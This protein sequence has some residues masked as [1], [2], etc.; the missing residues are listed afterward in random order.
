M[1]K[2]RGEQPHLRQ[3]SAR[4]HELTFS[5]A[6]GKRKTKTIHARN[7]THARK[8]ASSFLDKLER[9]RLGLDNAIELISLADAFKEYSVVACTKSSWP[10]EFG[11]WKNHILELEPIE[12]NDDGI[13]DYQRA[14]SYWR[15]RS[16]LSQKLLHEITSDHLEALYVVKWKAGMAPRSVR[17]LKAHLGRLFFWAI[18]KARKLKGE[19]PAWQSELPCDIP[20]SNPKALSEAQLERLLTL[21]FETFAIFFWLLFDIFTGLRRGEVCGLLWENVHEDS[22][23]IWVCRSFD[24]PT[25]GKRSRNV[26]IHPVLLPYVRR[27]RELATSAYVFPGPDGE[28]RSR[29]F[30]ATE[31]F[32]T[33]LKRA[34][35]I[36]GWV[37][38]CRPRRGARTGLA[39]PKARLTPQQVADIRKRA[40]S[41]EKPADIG[42]SFGVSRQVVLHHVRTGEAGFRPPGGC[43][44]KS[45]LVTDE[46]TGACPTCGAPLLARPIPL[47]FTFKDLRSS[48]GSYVVESTGGLRAAQ[49][50]LGHKDEET[51]DQHYA[52]RRNPFLEAQM[53]LVHIIP[54]NKLPTVFDG[55]GPLLPTSGN[56]S[57]PKRR[58]LPPVTVSGGE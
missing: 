14:P 8:L 53:A 22:G 3:R 43:K 26:P 36:Q 2:A 44:Y 28:M 55:E 29:N 49:L 42:R 37:Q 10:Q 34:G 13:P 5:D 24:T 41:G 39:N 7:K 47:A 20:E 33:C 30:K 27:A 35:L 18:R 45:E 56:Q 52:H 57:P 54:A 38:E 12:A 50:F 4:G 9:I 1:A 19:N 23:F 15:S 31:V 32:R 16:A 46:A 40:K 58:E 21:G 51:T 11:R 6:L 48:F 17:Q 25:K